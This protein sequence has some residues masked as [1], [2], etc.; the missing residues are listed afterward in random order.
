[1]IEVVDDFISIYNFNT[2]KKRM[3]NLPWFFGIVGIQNDSNEKMLCDSSDNYQFAHLF[4]SDH[5]IVSEY[6]DLI[7]PIINKLKI[8]ALIRIKANLNPKTSKIIEHTLHRD[9]NYKDS[10]TSVYYINSND[11]Y[12]LFEDGTKVESVENR[13]VTF[14]SSIMHTGTTCTNEKARVVINFNYF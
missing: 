10:F 4:Y 1:M 6:S 11:G 3:F 13:M 5:K 9:V 12:T 7:T 2:L 14:P 8:R